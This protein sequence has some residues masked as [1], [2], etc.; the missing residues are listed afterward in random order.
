MRM[1]FSFWKSGAVAFDPT[2][3]ALTGYWR[4]PYAGSPMVAMASAGASGANGNLTTR[5]VAPSVGTPVGGKAP[6]VFNGSTTALGAAHAFSTFGT[7]GSYSGWA[8]VYVAAI[9]T[10]SAFPS[11]Y[12]NNT[13]WSNGAYAG[14]VLRS[15]GSVVLFHY[16]GFFQHEASVAIATGAWCLVHWKYDGTNMRIGV[17]GTWGTATAAANCADL[18]STLCVS[19]DYSG[20]RALNGSLLEMAHTDAIITDPTIASIKG[21]YALSR[22]GLSL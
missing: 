15:S 7:A 5:G 16:D 18:T 17:N 13:I 1:P 19:E 6:A 2:A 11:L 20:V 14:V 9:S 3:L 10:D 12:D 8:I 4:A 22:Y 21:S